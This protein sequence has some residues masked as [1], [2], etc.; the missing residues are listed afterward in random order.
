MATVACLCLNIMTN[1]LFILT[2]PQGSGKTSFIKKLVALLV[3][4]SF[5]CEGFYADGYWENDMRSR[6][7][8]VEINGIN[9]ALLC[10]T[11]PETGD[12]PFRRFFFK[13]SGLRFGYKILKQAAG[14]H[15]CVFIDETGS[16]ELEGKGWAKA[17][18]L[19]CKK[20]PAILILTVRDCFVNKII[21]CFHLKPERVWHLNDCSPEEVAEELL[22]IS[23]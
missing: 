20:P 1:H 5:P 21:D 3:E 6:F 15:S 8:I 9:R 13:Q 7:E 22:C 17:L 4:A 10:D 18:E 23:S 2:G 14:K 16:L 19:L 11:H 12:I